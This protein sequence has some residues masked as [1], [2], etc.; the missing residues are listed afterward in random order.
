MSFRHQVINIVSGTQKYLY[1][2]RSHCKLY[3]MWKPVYQFP[4]MRWQS[5]FRIYTNYLYK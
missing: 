3:R 2:Q 1:A 5:R 4:Q